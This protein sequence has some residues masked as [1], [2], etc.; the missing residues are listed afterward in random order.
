MRKERMDK[1][2]YKK[3]AD[4][5][6]PNVKHTA[7][8]YE[9]LYPKRELKEGAMVT[10]YAPSPT[11]FQ[12][13]GGIF[14]ALIAERMAHQS[15][16][17]FY[18]R[19]EDTDRKREVEGGDQEI[20]K[21][22]NTYDIYFDEGLTEEG[23]ERGSYGPYKQSQRED[24]YKAYVKQMIENGHAYPC[25]CKGDEMEFSRGEQETLKVRKGYYGKWAK[26]RSLSF[27][28]VQYRITRE[29]N[30]IIR[31]KSP[32]N[33]DN[34]IILNDLIKGR[35]E[36]S[37]N[38]QDIVILKSDGLPTYHFAHAVDDHLMGTTHVT[39]ADEWLPSTSIHI[40][41]FD[42]LG[43]EFPK[44]AHI[45]PIL[46]M[47]GNSKRKLSKRKDP[48]I[49]FSYYNQ[50][51]YPKESV[52]EYLLSIANSNFEEWRRENP[53]ES[54]KSF[55]IGFDKIS[56]GGSLFDTNKLK[57]ISKNV[58]GY[59]EAE[60]IYELYLKWAVQYDNE[61][62]EL[63]RKDRDY[64]ID[65]F[66]IDRNIP[67]PRKD[68]ACWMDVR[69]NIGYYFDEIFYNKTKNGY[70][71][72]EKIAGKDAILILQEYFKI[73]DPN[74]DKTLWFERIRSMAEN[75]GYAKDMKAFKK[76]P[77]SF[78]GN[79]ADV[80]TV[81][82]VVVTNRPNSPDLYEIM[83]IIGRDRTIER[84]KNAIIYLQEKGV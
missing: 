4:L 20:I 41:L 23:T 64:A 27:D 14:A 7:E 32:G 44:F 5:L 42:L 21:A 11:G 1:M 78:K 30:Y 53:S 68:F 60:E 79:V 26:C 76:N 84:I 49:A 45:S 57:D 74:D 12:H 66:N 15:G 56:P 17:V 51:G 54:Y 18:L 28:E 8:Y 69:E 43:F 40:Q 77:E 36:L 61:M 70:D 3:L 63:L 35:V 47:D 19:I 25:F 50:Q 80:S 52:I 39:R 82:R 46:K 71:L 2:D 58:I 13:L 38:D 72:P 34:K 31:L 9:N 73:Y 62:A 33:W 67:K 75:L 48:E 37:E 29:E 24:I 10:R 22:L 16:G 81:I 6:L 65:F 55:K 59:M 83:K